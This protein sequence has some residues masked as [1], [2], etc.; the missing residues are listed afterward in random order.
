[1]KSAKSEGDAAQLAK[2]D[3][4]CGPGASEAVK[5]RVITDQA[6]LDLLFGPP[7]VESLGD[8][9]ALADSAAADAHENNF[10]SH[11]G[12]YNIEDTDLVCIYDNAPVGRTAFGAL[13][14]EMLGMLRHDLEAEGLRIVADGSYPKEGSQPHYTRVLLI[15]G[16]NQLDRIRDLFRK[17]ISVLMETLESA[18]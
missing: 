2:V 11:R 17:H 13:R 1:M 4:G 9:R 6:T 3:G 14:D 16:T 7:S 18:E 10:D 8:V 5:D 15:Q 12:L